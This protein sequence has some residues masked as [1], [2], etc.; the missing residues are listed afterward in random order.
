LTSIKFGNSQ[1]TYNVHRSKRRT[2]E[3]LVDASGVKIFTSKQKSQNEI[4]DLVKKHSRWIYRKK[5]H[6]KDLYGHKISYEAGSRLPYLGRGYVLQVI[7]SKD[8]EAF[9]FKNGRFIVKLRK[10][11]KSKIKEF[12]TDWLKQKLPAVLKKQVSKFT[13][14]L[15]MHTPKIHIKKQK[16]RWGSVTKKGTINFNQNLVKAPLK[17]I[18]YVVAHEVCHFK[19]PN[20]SSKYWELVYSIMPDYE[21]RKDW[22]RINWKL[23]NS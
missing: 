3:I 14:K 21:K 16:N 10:F 9:Y 19:I 6:F 7:I 5:I 8:K 17:I 15:G 22:L 20:H 18:D 13:K 11:R 4:H 12:Y 23:I 1:I 2:T